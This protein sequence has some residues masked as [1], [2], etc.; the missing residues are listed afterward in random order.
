M[1]TSSSDEEEYTYST[2]GSANQKN[3]E[4][5]KKKYIG[6]VTSTTNVTSFLNENVSVKKL[7][8]LFLIIHL[9]QILL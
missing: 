9:K 6:L 7:K 1:N 5:N 2:S 4:I 8:K 3:I